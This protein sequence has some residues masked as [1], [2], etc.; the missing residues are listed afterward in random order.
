VPVWQLGVEARFPGLGY[1]VF[2]GNVGTDT[3][4]ADLISRLRR[5]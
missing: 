5:T 4:L 2:P 1:V 3:A